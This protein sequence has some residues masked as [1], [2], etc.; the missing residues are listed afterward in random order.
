MIAWARRLLVFG[1][2][3]QELLR[4]DAQLLPLSVLLRP[5]SEDDVDKPPP[6]SFQPT[7]IAGNLFSN[8]KSRMSQQMSD[9][10]EAIRKKV[11]SP[12]SADATTTDGGDTSHNM[13][14]YST[15]LKG[16]DMS[17]TRELDYTD[18]VEEI[19][20][21]S[22]VSPGSQFEHSTATVS[23]PPRRRP[24]AAAT[25]SPK[26]PLLAGTVTRVGVTTSDED[27]DADAD[28]SGDMSMHKK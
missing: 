5:Q 15:P 7:K 18:E 2:T 16:A 23:T 6:S 26:A 28:V 21:A 8:V 12:R 22:V 14:E 19:Q 9:A 11:A 3:R 24:A 1:F 10:R 13:T 17:R 20:T 4:L 25:E 27:Y